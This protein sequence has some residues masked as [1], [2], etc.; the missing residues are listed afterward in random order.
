MI[1]APQV[2]QVNEFKEIAN[3]FANPLEIVREAIS[4][5][6]DAK[7]TEIHLIF[8]VIN[9]YGEELFRVRI[10]DNG[11]GMNE[12]EL[13]SFFDLGN[14]TR[15]G[16]NECIGEKGHGTKVY[17]HSRQIKIRTIKDSVCINAIMNDIYIQLNQDKIPSY[18]YDSSI[19]ENENNGTEIEIIGYNLNKYS[20][21][22]HETIKDYILWRTKFGSIDKEFGINLFN[23]NKIYLKGLDSNETEEL[24]FGHIFPNES[25]GPSALFDRY[26]NEA[27]DYFCKR[28]E[29][30]G[31]L[32]NF[33]HINY[34][35]VFYVEGKYI[36]YQYNNMLRRQG[37]RAPDGSY[38]IQERYGLW[39]C[40]DF[41]PIQRKNEW[42]VTKGSEYTKFHAFFNC[43]KFKLTA[44]RGS[45]EATTPEVFSDIEDI[46]KK[47]YNRITNSEEYAV[48]D[49]LQGEAKG[50]DTVKKEKD[51]YAR[52][53]RNALRQ[54]VSEFKGVKLYEPQLESGVHALLMQLSILSPDLFPFDMIDY[55]TNTGIDILVKEKNNLTVDQSR[56][57][58]I[59]LKNYLDKSFNHSFEYLY[60]I[61]CW[62][63][64]LSDG[65]EIIDIQHK[66]RVLRIVNPQNENDYTRFY[67]DELRNERRIVVYVLKDYLKEK[68]N[69]DFRPR[70]GN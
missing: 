56:I 60:S 20:A 8:D 25:E 17:F 1:K 7:A 62:D 12:K 35:A 5:S 53:K 55:N 9:H 11:K 47:I 31:V 22:K 27:P 42:I 36:K 68:L 44:N 34:Q 58:Y 4:N 61:V 69:I 48:L 59:E 57:Y 3:N 63:T 41:I 43:Q 28:W 15:I 39:L 67:L 46:V 54:K 21:F 14:S 49:W 51:E 37:Y 29:E 13:E 23:G 10:K 50:Y 18:E 66:K 2:N 45:V 16:D 30:K 52:R 26:S 19:V 33:P 40:K 65:D 64:R 24:T 70:L 6:F 32:P 38:T